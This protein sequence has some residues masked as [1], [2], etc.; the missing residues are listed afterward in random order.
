MCQHR[1]EGNIPD[2]F[3]LL[4]KEGILECS[5]KWSA[6]RGRGREREETFRMEF[7]N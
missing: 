4:K 1:E 5:L 6:L 7:L 3:F 2:G